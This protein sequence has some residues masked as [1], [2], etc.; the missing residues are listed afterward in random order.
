MSARQQS[1]HRFD[2]PVILMLKVPG[3][4]V[5]YD[6]IYDYGVVVEET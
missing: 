4:G 5:L 3:G 1:R 2:L 6:G